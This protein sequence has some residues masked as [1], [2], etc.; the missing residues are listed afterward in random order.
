MVAGSVDGE[1]EKTIAIVEDGR[2]S[3]NLVCVVV[4]QIAEVPHMTVS[5]E[6]D[7]I[8]KENVRKARILERLVPGNQSPGWNISVFV[9]REQLACRADNS[10]ETRKAVLHMRQ[11]HRLRNLRRIVFGVGLEAGVCSALGSAFVEN[12]VVSNPAPALGKHSV[13]RKLRRRSPAILNARSVSRKSDYG[14]GL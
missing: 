9:A 12:Y 2:G 11:S 1:R 5:I 8:K 6:D 10:L 3:D 7:C 4:D 13:C 14:H